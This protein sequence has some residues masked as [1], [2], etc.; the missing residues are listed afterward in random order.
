MVGKVSIILW[1]ATTIFCRLIAPEHAKWARTQALPMMLTFYFVGLLGFNVWVLY[2]TLIAYLPIVS[3]SRA[4]AAILFIV[5][6]GAVPDLATN[7][8]IGGASIIPLDK[9]FCLSFGL[10]IVFIQKGRTGLR[11]QGRFDLPYLLLLAVEY[12]QA[13]NLNFTSTM[14]SLLSTTLSMTIPYFTFSRSLTKAEDVRRAMVALTYIGFVLGLLGI[15]ESI[16]HFFVYQQMY[17]ALGVPGLNGMIYKMRGGLLRCVTSFGDA[18]G[19]SQFLAIAFGA[20]MACR[21]SFRSTSKLT[22]AL[23]VIA[24]GIFCTSSR[25]A[26]IALLIIVMSFDFYRRRYLALV[27]KATVLGGLFAVLMLAAEVSPYVATMMGNS[28]DTSS[29][30]D[31]RALL[32]KR[33]KEEFWKHPA[34]GIDASTVI[35]NMHDLVQGEGIVD[36]V[37]GYLFYA[38]TC[39]IGG[40][41]ALLGAFLGPSFAM[42]KSR[43]AM[44]L[45]PFTLNRYAAFVFAVGISYTITTAFTGFGG[46]G[47]MYYGIVIAMGGILYAWR[48]LPF[49]MVANSDPLSPGL[50]RGLPKVPEHELGPII[51]VSS[52]RRRAG[53]STLPS[54]SPLMHGNPLGE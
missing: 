44:A 48:K 43:R 3:R 31:Y 4:D 45:H 16:T 20:T 33:G 8:A 36:F 46:R 9:Y 23:V 42:L 15:F 18:T 53:G 50:K 47:A 6:L 29:T 38:L 41:L 24:G 19:F 14:R 34:I 54:I 2:I 30:A 12:A 25:N 26:W 39:G 49:E 52:R 37:N 7:I 1:I 10:M 13:R 27:G 40:I 35:K 28:Q 17:Y 32:L 51:P 11:F 21:Y 22:I 5:A